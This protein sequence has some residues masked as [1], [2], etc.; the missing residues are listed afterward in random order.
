[1]C[2]DK[3]VGATVGFPHNASAGHA[4]CRTCFVQDRL[5]AGHALCRTC[6]VQ[7]GNQVLTSRSKQSE[8]VEFKPSEYKHRLWFTYVC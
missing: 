4:L 8:V 5:C 6:F 2:W 7:C 1:M 3:N